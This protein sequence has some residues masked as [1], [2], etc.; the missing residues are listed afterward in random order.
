[1]QEKRFYVIRAQK[2]HHCIVT[3]K[4]L[5]IHSSLTYNIGNEVR[6]DIYSR[7]L[8]EAGQA[9]FFDVRVFNPNDM[10]YP[11]L[12]LPKLY[13]IN[14]KENKKYYNERIM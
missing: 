3:N 11:K 13:E 1:M 10:K 9:A 5:Q 14:E 2:K 6:L 7:G 12:E 8:R 4:S